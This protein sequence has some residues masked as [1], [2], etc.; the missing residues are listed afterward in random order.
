MSVMARLNNT[1]RSS[2]IKLTTIYKNLNKSAHHEKD[3]HRA[4]SGQTSRNTPCGGILG[5]RLQRAT[6][7]AISS[8][9][10]NPKG[11]RCFLRSGFD[12]C[13]SNSGNI[14]LHDRDNRGPW[15]PYSLVWSHLDTCHSSLWRSQVHYIIRSQLQQY[16]HNRYD[17]A[18]S[19]GKHGWYN[20]NRQ[21]NGH[22]N[23]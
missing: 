19:F 9:G 12:L 11:R 23:T 7:K 16:R 1:L 15:H 21:L 8:W 6:S 10:W 20:Q 3:R 5:R 14:G 4:N 2:V 18:D 17:W 13:R 22:I